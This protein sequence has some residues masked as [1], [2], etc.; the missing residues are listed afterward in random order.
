MRVSVIIPTFNRAKLVCE[1]VDSVLAQ[2]FREIEIIVI[3]DG[4]T[5]DTESALRKYGSRIRYVKQENRG[6]N[7]ARHRG[8][9]IATGDYVGLLDSDD[10]WCPFK[11][12]LDAALLDANPDAALVFSDFYILKPDG[13]LEPRGLPSWFDSTPDWSEILGPPR[14]VSVTDIPGTEGIGRAAVRVHTGDVYHM[15]L[16]GPRVLP[17]ASLY[18]RSMAA[19]FRLNEQDPYCGDWEFFSLLSNKFQVMF[20]DAETAINRSHE[21][22]V[23]LTRADPRHWIINRLAVIERVWKRD[24]AF[25]ATHQEEVD[26]EIAAWVVRLLKLHLR[27]GDAGAARAAAETLAGLPNV[28]LPA[29]AAFYKHLAATPGAARIVPVLD[30]LRQLVSRR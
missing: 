5:D 13:R 15:S 21:D 7:A 8:L 30:S 24:A 4:S 19:G 22:A 2:T 27:A 1:A 12:A 14:E 10:M 18:R 9:E 28:K 23:R 11:A 29:S 3:D 25:Y 6:L 26:G 16:F 20:V 17:T